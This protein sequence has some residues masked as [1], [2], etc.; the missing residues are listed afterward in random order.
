[1][2]EIDIVRDEE[3]ARRF[4]LERKWKYAKTYPQCPHQ[5]V[6]VHWEKTKEDLNEFYWFVKHLRKFGR[7][8]SWYKLKNIYLTVDGLKY[9]TM[10]EP[11]NEV[12]V[13]NRAIEDED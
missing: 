13:I 9:W 8:R 7:E 6:V 10:G 5:Y 2:D 11:V 3:R 12:I 1:M 4:I